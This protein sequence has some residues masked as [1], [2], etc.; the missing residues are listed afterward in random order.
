MEFLISFVLLLLQGMRI[1]LV[2]GT[3]LPY[4]LPADNAL[5]LGIARIIDPVLRPFRKLIKPISGFD[6]T[7]L[8]LYMLLILIESLINRF[9]VPLV[10]K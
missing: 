2:L 1:F 4:I 10:P 9:L 7:P 3:L 5:R 6:F 8:V